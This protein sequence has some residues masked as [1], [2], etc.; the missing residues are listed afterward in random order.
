M[1]RYFEIDVI[2]PVPPGIVPVQ[3]AL[4][5]LNQE[6]DLLRIYICEGPPPDLGET[7]YQTI[8]RTRNLVKDRGASPFVFFLDSDVVL[9][10]GSL[11]A[12]A[13][14]LWE[15]ET[16]GALAI[17]YMNQA[18][19]RGISASHV[20]M[21]ATLWRRK[22]LDQIEFRGEGE[23]CDCLSAMHDCR[24]LGYKIEYSYGLHAAHLRDLFKGP[25][26]TSR[27]AYERAD[28]AAQMADGEKVQAE[29]NP[30][31]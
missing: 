16:I 1:S 4:H 19:L 12:L 14:E 3:A 10:P 18:P 29:T 28:A 8:A 5:A 6:M 2:I 21:G 22:V 24:A 27:Q 30:L 23:Q 25:Q 13:L 9:N 7:R 15:D 26:Y 20:A 31:H 17:D 11:H